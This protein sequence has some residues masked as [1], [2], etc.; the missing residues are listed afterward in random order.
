MDRCFWSWCSVF[1]PGR[2]TGKPDCMWIARNNR[3]PPHRG[4]L[5]LLYALFWARV[6]MNWGRTDLKYRWQIP[7][8]S[9]WNDC[10]VNIK[11][12]LKWV[13]AKMGSTWGLAATQHFHL[14]TCKMCRISHAYHL[15][16]PFVVCWRKPTSLYNRYFPFL[17]QQVVFCMDRNKKSYCAFPASTEAQQW[18][19]RAFLVS[20]MVRLLLFTFPSSLKPPGIDVRHNKEGVVLVCI[21]GVAFVS[22]LRVTHVLMVLVWGAEGG[23][24]NK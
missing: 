8:A 5:E 4:S 24:G 9:I 20:E 10:Q 11:A 19:L 21:T 15:K 7:M 17:S 22:T 13:R 23:K 18:D 1:S 12:L 6:L 2:G 16:V 14:A 3:S